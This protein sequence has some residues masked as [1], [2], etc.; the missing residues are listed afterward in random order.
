[1]SEI[2]LENMDKDKLHFHPGIYLGGNDI[3]VSADLH[4]SQTDEKGEALFD[5]SFYNIALFNTAF[6]SDDYDLFFSLTKQQVLKGWDL[7]RIPE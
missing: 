4:F 6:I 3:Q 2:Q 5:G 7:S 1:M